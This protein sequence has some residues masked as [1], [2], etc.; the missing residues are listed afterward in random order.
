MIKKVFWVGIAVPSLLFAGTNSE[1]FTMELATGYRQ[2][3]LNCKTYTDTDEEYLVYQERYKCVKYWQ[4]ELTL[5]SINSDI[6]FMVNGGFAGFGRGRLNQ[7]IDNFSTMHSTASFH[8]RSTGY[9]GSV[10]GVLGYQVNLLEGRIGKFIITPLIGYRGYWERIDKHSSYT[11]T[12]QVNEGDDY[13]L[14]NLEPTSK[15]LDETWYA[16]IVGLDVSIEPGSKWIFEFNYLFHWLRMNH[17]SFSKYRIRF[18]D[19]GVL[20]SDKSVLRKSKTSTLS[21]DGHEGF[22]KAIYL[23]SKHWTTAF[24]AKFHYFDIDKNKKRLRTTVQEVVTVPS[25]STTSTKTKDKFSATWWFMS[26]LFE[27]G[28]RF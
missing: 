10:Y 5:R 6:Y 24:K 22:A 8:G 12:V 18:Y 2:D 13:Y 4:T 11:T 16:P 1:P 20:S 7:N 23:V 14:L 21:G 15:R 25:S 27:V 26:F 28:Y 19:S 17:K 9:D 3:S